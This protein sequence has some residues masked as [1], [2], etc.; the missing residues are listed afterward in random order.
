[1]LLENPG[2]MVTREQLRLRLWPE[3]MFVDFDHGLNSAIQR[4][5]DCLSDSAAKPRWIETIPRRGYRFVAPVEWLDESA[6]SAALPQNGSGNLEEDSIGTSTVILSSKREFR[7]GKL[8]WALGLFTVT[9]LAAIVVAREATPRIPEPKALRFRKLTNTPALKSCPYS[10]GNLVYFN[11]QQDPDAPLTLMQLSTTGGDPLRIPTP[12]Q[13]SVLS[14]ISPDGG[15][16]LLATGEHTLHD[17]WIFPVPGGTPQRVGDV[18]AQDA[19]FSFDANKIIF[20]NGNSLFEIRADG[21][22]LRKL[23]TASGYLDSPVWSPDGKRIR[24]RQTPAYSHNGVLWEASSDG[25]NPHPLFSGIGGLCCGTWTSDGKYF[26]YYSRREGEE[27][28]WAVRENSGWL[29][30]ATSKAVL[31]APSSMLH[32]CGWTSRSG[33]QIFITG[34]QPQAQLTRFDSHS[35]RFLPFLG[36]LSAE[37]VSFS[38]DGNWVAYT[39]YPEGELWRSRVDGS[40]RLKLTGGMGTLNVEWSPDGKQISFVAKQP[41]SALYVISADG[42]TP[43]RL[44]SGDAPVLSH[45]WSPHGESMVIG[46]WIKTSAPVLRILDV[47]TKQLSLIPG[48]EGM[49]FPAWSPDGCYISASIIEGAKRGGW[50]Y[51]LS[52]GRWKSLPIFGPCSWSHDSQSIYCDRRSDSEAAVVRVRVAN[53]RIEKV[54]SLKGIHRAD[55]AFGE[56]FGLDTNNAPLVLR[57]MSSRQIYALDWEAP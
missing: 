44:P 48:S 50:L 6:L 42:G 22:R 13:E 26:V 18:K 49:L 20:A 47:K 32:V 21:A 17:L 19:A 31:L 8:F 46:E 52:T 2:E 39:T 34:E 29:R 41:E 3:D 54:V 57:D 1:M 4:L 11:Q 10:A 45:S 35:G 27:G 30:K 24:Y 5:R 25:S 36:G 9:L 15:K 14:D 37:Y 38:R 16:L 7:G 28:F 12:L 53:G 40:E 23:L 56:W 51:E 43:Q 33:N 55:G